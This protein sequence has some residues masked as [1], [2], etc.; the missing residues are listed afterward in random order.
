MI[1]CVPSALFFAAFSSLTNSPLCDWD[2]Q[3]LG[4]G[5]VTCLVLAATPGDSDHIWTRSGCSQIYLFLV[6]LLEGWG[7]VRLP[8]PDPFLAL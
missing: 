7:G 4:G 1:A 2:L 5:M 3:F 8:L 6:H